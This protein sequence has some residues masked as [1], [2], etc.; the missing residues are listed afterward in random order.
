MTKSENLKL[1]ALI[2]RRLAMP[3][4]LIALASAYLL[5]EGATQLVVAIAG[6]VACVPQI[7]LTVRRHRRITASRKQE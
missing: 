3:L 4:L 1:Y 5:S 7:V 2:G 6:I